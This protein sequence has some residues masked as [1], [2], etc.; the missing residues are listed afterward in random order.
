M[1]SIVRAGRS[2]V[3]RRLAFGMLTLAV[4]MGILMPVIAQDAAPGSGIYFA[5]RSDTN[6]DGFVDPNDPLSLYRAQPGQDAVLISATGEDVSQFSISA[7]GSQIAYIA[8]SPSGSVLTMRAAGSAESIQVSLSDM[9]S[10][11]SIDAFSDAVWVVGLNA[12]QIPVLRGFSPADGSTL[13]DHT[14]RRPNTSVSVHSSGQFVLAYNAESGGLSVLRLPSM[15][16]VQFPLTGY[17]ASTPLWSPT[18]PRF[19]MGVSADTN[20]A[21]AQVEM[22]DVT[23][24]VTTSLYQPDF[25]ATEPLQLGWSTGGR[26]VVVSRPADATDGRGLT[27]IDTSTGGNTRLQQPNLDLTAAAWSD[28]DSYLLLS[29]Q[30][31]DGSPPLLVLYTTAANTGISLPALQD[32][33]IASVAW[34]GNPP[35]LAALGQSRQSGQFS[36]LMLEPASG[37]AV[38]LFDGIDTSL[39]TSPLR[40]GGDGAHVYFVANSNDAVITSLGTPTAVFAAETGS[41]GSVERVS[42]ENVVVD[43]LVLQAR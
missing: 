17:A 20:L 2:L 25:S 12:D 14:F 19:V 23:S 8:H 41:S 3:R 13:G 11:V 15:E 31:T 42:P 10:P 40:W 30:P 26:Y 28:D 6:G 27:L 39:L 34:K 22:I 5:G 32:F 24:G 4:L 43:T 38:S 35:L 18:A 9:V 1:N 16:L 29:E 33:S 21:N 37:A 36:L 7:D